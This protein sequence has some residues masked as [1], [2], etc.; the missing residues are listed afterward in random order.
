MLDAL[1]DFQLA[2]AWTT[3]EA[4]TPVLMIMEETAKSLADAERRALEM[5]RDLITGF[6]RLC[7]WAAARRAGEADA[8][9]HLESAKEH[10][11]A[12]QERFPHV[13]F[14]AMRNA[15]KPVADAIAATTE[16]NTLTSIALLLARI[17]VPPFLIPSKDPFG[18]NKSAGET[19]TS[20]SEGPF[21]VRVMLTLD[22]RPWSNPQV[23]GAATLYDLK[24]K[25]TAPIWPSRADRL[26][27]DFVTTLPLEH[28]R[29]SAFEISRD[30]NSEGAEQTLTGQIEFPV[31]QSLLAE[32]VLLQMRAT[33]LSTEDT[34]V[35][36]TATI[37]GY[38]KLRVRVS[39]STA[40]PLLSKYK[41]LDE[42]VVA[43]IN[44]VRD[45][46]GIGEKHL[47]D[48]I[49]ALSIIVNYMGICAQQ[50]VYRSGQA[51]LEKDFQRDL[52]MHMRGQLGE[53][54][55][56]APKQGGG[57]TDISYRSITV[58]LKV[59]HDIVDRGEMLR[60]YQNQP[61]QYS[62]AS[63]AQLGILC[64]LDLTE[65]TLPPA[66]P[67]NN[68]RLLSPPVHGFPA[69][70]IPFPTRIAAVVI[71]GNIRRPSD[72]SR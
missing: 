16:T 52:L 34:S 19:T 61:T 32:P 33:F 3:A 24:A 44:D 12:A 40:T 65:K 14:G 49:E 59:E 38:H 6:Q 13:G 48:F 47:T 62:S 27:L 70:E 42:R 41:A 45:L 28:R 58:E 69:G 64:V 22:G 71:D 39:D 20:V 5:L 8:V 60:G 1:A 18:A 2:K 67:Q 63:G 72:Y 15:A 66:P 25:V 68:L 10:A 4:L 30:S 36:Y 46:A 29:V 17:P 53:D 11:V 51:I 57:I 23:L 31:G 35:Q 50:A 54:V 43:I 55:Q 37:V 26:V 21:V 9:R 7:Q 56:E